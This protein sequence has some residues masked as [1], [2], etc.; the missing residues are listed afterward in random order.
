MIQLPYVALC[1][2][3]RRAWNAS[4]QNNCIVLHIAQSEP[5][6]L[7][8][9]REWNSVMREVLCTV[10]MTKTIGRLTAFDAL[11]P[12]VAHCV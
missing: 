4:Q 12:L 10:L 6:K 2:Q 1:C 7:L 11:E 8:Y 5:R 3:G 9:V